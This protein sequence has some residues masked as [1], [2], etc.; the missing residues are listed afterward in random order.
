MRKHNAFVKLPRYGNPYM[1]N[2][3]KWYFLI[4]TVNYDTVRGPFE[5]RILAEA[6]IHELQRQTSLPTEE[7]MPPP[8]NG[9]FEIEEHLKGF[10][11]YE[12]IDG[13][14]KLYS[15]HFY[16]RKQAEDFIISTQEWRNKTLQTPTADWI[17]YMSKRGV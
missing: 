8:P 17:T 10:Y 2:D 1:Q 12:W 15:K 16:T 4:K 11:A 5:T 13:R 6:R 7:I 3:G 14:R 9:T